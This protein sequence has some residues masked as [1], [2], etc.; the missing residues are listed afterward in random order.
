MKI[1][2]FFYGVKGILEKDPLD[3]KAESG[4]ENEDRPKP[5]QQRKDESTDQG[6]RSPYTEEK[7]TNQH[8]GGFDLIGSR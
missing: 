1:V 4:K 8:Y 6:D 5:N 3:D 2:K 7:G